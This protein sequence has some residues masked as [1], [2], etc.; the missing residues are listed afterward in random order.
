MEIKPLP[1]YLKLEDAAELFGATPRAFLEQMRGRGVP[2]IKMG[3]IR[4][5]E[6]RE[7]VQAMDTAKDY[8]YARGEKS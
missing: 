1:E 6:T 3:H 5:F 8:A 7:L 2:L 4:V